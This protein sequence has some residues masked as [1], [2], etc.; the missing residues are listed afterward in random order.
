MSEN[1]EKEYRD[2][3]AS[4]ALDYA[5]HVVFGQSPDYDVMDAEDMLWNAL[6]GCHWTIYYYAARNVLYWS[7]NDNAIFDEDADISGM[8]SMTEFFCLA[9]YYA[10]QADVR[11]KCAKL[12]KDDYP[13]LDMCFDNLYLSYEK[14]NDDRLRFIARFEQDGINVTVVKFDLKEFVDEMEGLSC[15]F[16]PEHKLINQLS[17]LKEELEGEYGVDLSL[18]MKYLEKDVVMGCETYGITKY[19][20]DG[21]SVDEFMNAVKEAV[22]NAAAD[23]D[24]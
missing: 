15:N 20:V 8:K 16:E 18:S 17:E 23:C 22:I 24:D 12:L 10:M 7:D 19:L 13:E 5:L 3:I 11:D 6:D 4:T 9:A 14:N 1:T 21:E 2:F